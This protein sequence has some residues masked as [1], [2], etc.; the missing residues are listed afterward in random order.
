[1]AGL[2]RNRI[3]VFEHDT[4]KL[5]QEFISD[6]KVLKFEAKYLESLHKFYGDKGVPYFSLTHNGIKFNEYVGVL[7]VGDLSIEVLPKADK[8]DTNKESWKKLLID[9]LR[10]VG[11][12]EI[13][14]PSSSPLNL[15][16]NSVLDIYFELFVKEV[17]FL[18]H[19]GLIKKYRK[20][21]GNVTALKGSLQFSKH[22]QQ[23]LTH[24]ERFYTR[25][26]TYDVK[27][28]L[29]I[30]LY[31]TLLLLKQ[32]NTSA[33]LQSRIGSL[34]L[35]FPEMPS[36][37]INEAIFERLV[38]NRKSDR[39]KKAIEIARLL[40]LNYHPDLS[41]GR[42][43]IL[44]LMFDMNLLW[45][46]FILVSL[47]KYHPNIKSIHA[48]SQKSFWQ[49]EDGPKSNIKPDIFIELNDGKKIVLDTKWKN[50]YGRN[51]S[52]EDL[53][54]MYAYGEY[55]NASSVNLVYPGN[56]NSKTGWFLHKDNESKTG[57][58]CGIINISPSENISVW[59]KKIAMEI[60]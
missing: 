22:I 1:M 21:E 42:N 11:A 36:I 43:N 44:A 5:N 13:H 17:E 3:L 49:S 4:I 25:Y 31:K 29:H 26:T 7:R 10:K 24:Q 58:T 54:Q 40:L 16:K 9:M 27:H 50:L 2:R 55:Y 33:S 23:N 34:L 35:E 46:K 56:D 52:P 51:P 41:K 30:I 32:I 48:Q 18:I 45:E 53:R 28:Q 14:S 6:E 60:K 38:F 12:F 59:M 8:N 19:A 47:R 15:K 37:H 57:R 39:Y 20:T